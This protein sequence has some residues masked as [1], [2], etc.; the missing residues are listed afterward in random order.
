MKKMVLLLSILILLHGCSGNDDGKA[1]DSEVI[2][3]WK[4]VESMVSDGGP[5]YFITVENGY[6]YTFKNNGSL[7][8]VGEFD[9]SGTYDFDD[10]DRIEVAIVDCP[11]SYPQIIASIKYAV[12]V[13]GN[14][15]TLTQDP[16]VADEGGAEIFE[17]VD[18]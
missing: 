7:T 15:L 5:Y 10:L 13:S 4:H 1:Q 8:A 9:C 16:P 14:K 3:K 11:A 17:R 18:E 12:S 6:T 2:G